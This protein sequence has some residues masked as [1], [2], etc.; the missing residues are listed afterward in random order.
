MVATAVD[1]TPELIVDGKTGLAVPPG[2]SA[3]LADAICRLLREP[4]LAQALGR[5]G[6]EWVVD[7]FSREGQIRRTQ[8]FYL[9]AWA[10]SRA[11]KKVFGQGDTE[12]WGRTEEVER[13]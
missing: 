13:T 5:A 8:D 11:R 3:R 4:G 1:G 9:R 12:A 2:D 10:E 6:R 7:R